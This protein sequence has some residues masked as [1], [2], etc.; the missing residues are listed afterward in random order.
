MILPKFWGLNGVWA[1]TP[2]ADALA[3]VI[4]I[5]VLRKSS[6]NDKRSYRNMEQSV[7]LESHGFV[8]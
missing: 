1:A 6:T 3:I 5:I 4:T 2:I 7:T 8:S